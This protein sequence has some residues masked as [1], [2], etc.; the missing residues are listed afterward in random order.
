MWTA[1]D[2]VTLVSKSIA[3]SWPPADYVLFFSTK[4]SKQTLLKMKNIPHFDLS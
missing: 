3:Q 4:G 1:L 2:R